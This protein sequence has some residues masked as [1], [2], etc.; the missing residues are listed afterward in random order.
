M[1]KFL[2]ILVCEPVRLIGLEECLAYK[3][4]SSLAVSHAVRRRKSI[5][6][7]LELSVGMVR[8]GIVM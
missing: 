3:P 7:K 2:F 8:R 1:R 4:L 6:A 5:R